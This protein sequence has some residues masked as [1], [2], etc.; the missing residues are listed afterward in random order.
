MLI[1]NDFQNAYL[2]NVGEEQWTFLYTVDAGEE[3]KKV[4]DLRY[5]LTLL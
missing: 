5:K 4:P 1:S 3:W 2:L